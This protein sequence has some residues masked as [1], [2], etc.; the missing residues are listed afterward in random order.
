MYLVSKFEPIG[1]NWPDSQ[2]PVHR[3]QGKE[4]GRKVN[5]E[6]EDSSG[7]QL[8]TETSSTKRLE[9]AQGTEKTI[10]NNGDRDICG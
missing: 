9:E 6:K 8:G 3:Q 10:E 1:R 7:T 2:S 4:R 5:K